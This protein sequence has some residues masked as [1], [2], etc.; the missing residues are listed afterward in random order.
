MT[1]AE[2]KP[3]P[4]KNKVLLSLP[5]DEYERVSHHLELVQLEHNQVLHEAEEPIRAVY[6][7]NDALISILSLLSDGST[8]EIGV[9]GR[10]G[11][12]DTSALLGAEVSP[13]QSLVQ[14][15]GSAFRMKVAPFKEELKRG[16]AFQ[17][18]L[19]RYASLLIAQ[20]A[21]VAVCN[22][23]HTIEERLARWLLTSATRVES[24]ELPLTQEF[25]SHMLGVRR[26][27]VTV[28]ARTLQTAGMIK[29]NRG[30]ITIIDFEGLES[31]ACE[32]YQNMKE[33]FNRYMQF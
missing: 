21:Q 23:L 18:I 26:A 29:Y 2:P 4:T 22:S 10:E 33:E 27:G 16:G 17:T 25:L 15:P 11:L 8:I 12:S 32:C 9:V 24:G 31:A 5:D 3:R 20:I 1:L 7:I 6:F 19:L 30:H 13:H 28:A 14:I